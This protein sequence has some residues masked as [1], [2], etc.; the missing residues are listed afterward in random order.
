MMEGKPVEA[1]IEGERI[2]RLNDCPER[3][4][5]YVLYWMQQSQRAEFNPALEWAVGQANA[6][7]LPLVV[8]FGLTDGYPEANLRH[9]RFML[10]GLRETGESLKG[11]GIA[12]VVRR[13]DPAAVALELARDAALVVCDRGYLRHQREWRER[14]AGE[15]PCPV[16]EVEADVVVPLETASDHAEY[17]ART[18]RPKLHRLLPRFLRPLP[19]V[20]LERDSLR[21][22][23]KGEGLEAPEPLL[24][25]LRL[26]RSVPPV[27]HF[28]RGG[29]GEAK[30]RLGELLGEFRGYAEDRRRPER[31]RVSHLSKYLHFGQVSPVWAALEVGKAVPAED[32]EA[33]LEE[34]LV[35]RELAQNRAWFTPDYDRYESLPRWARETLA[36]HA[37]DP[38]PHLY[39][40]EALERAAT[41]DR[42]WNAAMREMRYTGS[43]HNAMRMYWGKKVLEWS[44][45]PE[46]GFYRTLRLNNRYFLDGRDASSY[47]NVGWIYGLHDRPWGR[48]PIFGTV[49]C[50]AAS[51]LE[52]KCD[53]DAYVERVDRLVREARAAGIRFPEDEPPVTARAGAP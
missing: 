31:D 45:T 30:R 17:A 8:G 21:L 27:T 40:D 53:I 52:R 3:P 49:R 11:R 46:E 29:T 38:R 19:R 12:L 2:R 33:F 20:P 6:V 43:M 39:E 1:A 37:D 51:G 18:L 10:E 36:A 9:Y 35:R 32:R 26:D 47:A 13:G 28:F 22:D 41:H 15:A 5:R 4:G 50:L 42:Y 16:W 25:R 7:R 48:R 24:D 23:L 34:L 14:I 44:P